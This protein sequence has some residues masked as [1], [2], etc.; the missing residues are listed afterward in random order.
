M[1]A[2]SPQAKPPAADKTAASDRVLTVPNQLTLA[3]VLLTIVLFVLIDYELYLASLIVFIIAA[4]TDWIDGYWAR[5][6]GQ[7]T[8]LGRIFDPFADKLIICGTFIYLAT[9]DQSGIT[10]WMAVLV[11]GRELLV[12]A[13]RG[14]FET[15][16]IDFSASQAGK[17][18]ML[19]QCIAA[20]MSLAYLEYH[21][22]IAEHNAQW[23]DWA[24]TSLIVAVWVAIAS[25]IYSGMG[26]I[27]AAI[28]LVRQA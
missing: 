15:H 1:S 13:M 24:S 25:T 22:A 23:A 9:I 6:Y 5:K 11:V 7:V 28:K 19:F 8:V 18:K 10:A 2:S 27:G 3:R 17:W 26:Y 20:G 14:H 4:S 16:G 21:T 12:T